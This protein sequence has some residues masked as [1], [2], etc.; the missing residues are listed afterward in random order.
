MERVD[1]G[2]GETAVTIDDELWEQLIAITG[3]AAG[4]CYQCGACTA[5]CPWGLVK[6]ETLSIRRLIR[7]AQLGLLGDENE[8][9]LCTTCTH[10]DAY[11]PRGV[12][13]S[14]VIR[15]LRYLSWERREIPSGLPS[16]MWSVFW[17]N[18]PWTQPPSQR[19]QWAK[20]LDLPTFDAEQHEI[21]LYI[22]CTPSYDRRA[23]KIGR[24]LVRTLRAAGVSFGYLGDDEPCCGESAKSLGH[25]PFFRETVRQATELF[26]ARGVNTL[27][28]ISPHCYDAFKNYEGVSEKGLKPLHYSQYLAE[29]IEDGRLGF[30]GHAQVRATFHDPCY[31][32]RHNDE[33]AA[34]RRVLEAVPGLTLLEMDHSARD[35]LCCGGGGGRM[36]LETEAGERISDIRLQEALATGASVLATACPFCISCLEDSLKAQNTRELRV[37]D[38]AEIAAAAL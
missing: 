22:G 16:V 27:V 7:R 19:S 24:A 31:L 29:L 10:C 3:G 15:G 18:N 9:W 20:D 35:T 34:P 11:C 36:W 32:A 28:T 13:V 21:L 4:P 23:Q 17:N 2:S 25:E 12:P 6:G 5:V 14:E 33:V 26:A 8:L 1:P 37:M 30:D 38:V